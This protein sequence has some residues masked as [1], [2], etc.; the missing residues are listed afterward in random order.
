M[1]VVSVAVRPKTSMVH[2]VLP[3]PALVCVD[4]R[5]ARAIVPRL[6]RV[7]LALDGPVELLLGEQRILDDDDARD[8]VDAVCAHGVEHRA[9]PRRPHRHVGVRADLARERHVRPVEDEAPVVL[10]VQN[11]GVHLRL[12]GH[13]DELPH[14]LAERRPPV[15][16]EAAHR[17][18]PRHERDARGLGIGGRAARGVAGIGCLTSGFLRRVLGAG[19]EDDEGERREREREPRAPAENRGGHPRNVAVPPPGV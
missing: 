5:L 6:R 19:G 10:D 3:G 4:P 9:Q 2:G 7:V 14:L 1:S 13:L 15:H 8:G 16:V 12:P 17:V 11:K 18:G